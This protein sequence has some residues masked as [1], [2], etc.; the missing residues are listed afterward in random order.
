MG[1]G[2]KGGQVQSCLEKEP[3]G[4]WGFKR[5]KKKRLDSHSYGNEDYKRRKFVRRCLVLRYSTCFHLHPKP[6][7]VKNPLEV[8][9]GRFVVRWACNS[10]LF[11]QYTAEHGRMGC[12]LHNLRGPSHR[13]EAVSAR[14]RCSIVL[15]PYAENTRGLAAFNK[16]SVKCTF[17]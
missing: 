3:S 5:K 8:H 17:I 13:D 16:I 15:P 1:K 11:P 4:W 6:R 2:D 12:V 10:G 7:K 9:T 14:V